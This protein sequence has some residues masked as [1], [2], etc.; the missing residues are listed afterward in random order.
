MMTR[1]VTGSG[2]W[3]LLG[4]NWPVQGFNGSNAAQ[5]SQPR[6]STL[7]FHCTPKRVIGAARVLS[8]G[9][10]MHPRGR[11]LRE[12]MTLL[13]HGGAHHPNGDE[14]QTTT[15]T[16]TTDVQT[17]KEKEMNKR[18]QG[19]ENMCC[20]RR[21]RGDSQ[22]YEST[23]KQTG[24]ETDNQSLQGRLAPGLEGE[25]DS[26]KS[27]STS[28]SVAEKG[29]KTGCEPNQYR[30]IPRCQSE[31]LYCNCQVGERQKRKLAGF[32]CDTEQ[33]GVGKF[34]IQQI[35]SPQDA[36]CKCHSAGPSRPRV[37]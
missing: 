29:R 26:S 19:P 31:E 35:E 15:T 13:I 2:P 8:R 10:T 5:L 27:Q 3:V 36:R 28:K 23:A 1:R 6:G 37:G 18:L 33:L 14:H 17:D 32:H 16:T 11:H 9:V 34:T 30:L 4:Y 12:G 20:S 22:N 24:R 7:T 25:Q 21:S